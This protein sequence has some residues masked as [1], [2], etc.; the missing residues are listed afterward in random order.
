MVARFIRVWFF[1]DERNC[2]A[3][4]E[5][6][7]LYFLQTSDSLPVGDSFELLPRENFSFQLTVPDLPVFDQKAG[8]AL[9][10]PVDLFMAVQESHDQGIDQQQRS[11]AD[12]P[13]RNAIV[14]AND[15]VLYGV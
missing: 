3:G 4:F 5:D 12:N 15:G 10:D 2:A 8:L 1:Y 11:S 7:A 13:A 6:G 9:N 14:I